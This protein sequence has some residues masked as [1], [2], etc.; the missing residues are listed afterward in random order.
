MMG[1][2]HE[3]LRRDVHEPR[4]DLVGRG[5]SRES[6]SVR[7]PEHMRVDRNRRF[8]P[9]LMQD[10]VCRFSANPGQGFKLLARSRGLPAM[11]FNDLAR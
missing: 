7:D 10:D 1:A 2:L 4:L 3:L 11:K 6:G 9:R 8:A 5:S